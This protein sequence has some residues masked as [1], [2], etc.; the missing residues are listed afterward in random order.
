MF[1]SP[2]SGNY[3]S[4][5]FFFNVKCIYLKK[6][7]KINYKSVFVYSLS[8]FF[9]PSSSAPSL[10]PGQALGGASDA[11]GGQESRSV[12]PL[13]DYMAEAARPC[14]HPSPGLWTEASPPSHSSVEPGSHWLG[15]GSFR[16]N[17]LAKPR[18]AR[19]LAIPVAG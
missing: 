5:A 3:K 4:K 16:S 12:C 14:G 9:Q 13:G 10:S 17:V 11:A 18:G 7:Y 2:K 8:L 1:F 15:P 6:K 19:A